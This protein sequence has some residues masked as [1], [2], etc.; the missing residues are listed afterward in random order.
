MPIIAEGARL[1]GAALGVYVRCLLARPSHPPTTG[2][3][4]A[5]PAAPFEFSPGVPPHALPVATIGNTRP[6]R[7]T[8]HGFRLGPAGDASRYAGRAY[9][10]RLCRCLVA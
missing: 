4:A 5:T 8:V 9:R 1:H 6:F 2:T 7:G 10:A 3:G